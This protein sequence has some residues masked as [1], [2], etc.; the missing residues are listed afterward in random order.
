MATV[1]FTNVA[2]AKPL[3]YDLKGWYRIRVRDYRV[4]FYVVGDVVV[5]DKIGDRKDVYDE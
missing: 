3:R 1:K 4:R 5:I 2:G